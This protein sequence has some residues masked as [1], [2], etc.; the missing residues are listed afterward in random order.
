MTA[1]ACAAALSEA[2]D[3]SAAVGAVVEELLALVGPQPD[4]AVLFFS[5][6]HIA[7]AEEIVAAVRRTLAPGTLLG[8][9]SGM[10]AGGA[11]EVEEGPALSLWAG[12]TGTVTPV[13]LTVE[14]PPEAGVLRGWPATVPEDGS[15]LVLLTDPFTFPAEAAL[16]RLREAGVALP[17]AG[18]LASAAGRPGGNRLVLDDRVVDNGAV[19]VVLGPGAQVATVVSQGCRPIGDPFIVAQ[20][21]SN[22]LLEL[23]GQPALRRLHDLVA[24]LEPEERELA[25]RGLHLGIVTDE[26]KLDFAR[27]D[28]LI[29]GVM[30][31]D[32]ETGAIAA[33]AV[34]P[35]GT[36]VQFQVRN[37]ESAGMDLRALLD[38]RSA[39]GALL[40]TCNGRGQRLFGR[41][42]HDASIVSAAL[43]GAPLAGMSCAGEIGPVGDRSYVHGFTASVVLLGAA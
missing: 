20:A 42:D 16:A 43:D 8:V 14:G 39:D 29:R 10:V 5:T 31:A 24:S 23:G 35:V 25:M 26:R 17:V 33:G 22:V 21:R 2:R 9:S 40:F 3:P 11:R 37:A 38:G 1:I 28:F 36:T 6:H 32:R 4:L 7:A 41:P 19:G 27:G 12:R 13:R 34:V 15:G 18:G 30:G